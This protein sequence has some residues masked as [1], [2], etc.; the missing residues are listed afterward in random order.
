MEKNSYLYSMNKSEEHTLEI[1]T[2]QLSEERKGRRKAE[3]KLLAMEERHASEMAALQKEIASLREE[4]VHFHNGSAQM[5]EMSSMVKQLVSFMM[6]NEAVSMSDSLKAAVLPE[7]RKEFELQKQELCKGFERQKQELIDMYERKITVL[8]ERLR[9]YEEGDDD[10]SS[11]SGSPSDDLETRVKSAEQQCADLRGTAYGQRTESGKYRH[12]RQQAEDADTMDLNGEDVPEE[13]VVK[14]AKAIREYRDM[15]GVSKPRRE[16][17]LAR[18]AKDI[19]LVPENLPEDACE[20]G[21]DVTYRFGYIKGYIRVQRIIRKKYRDS[22]GNYY[23]I[24]LPEKYRNCM[25]R[26]QATETLI[27]QILTMH[28]QQNMTLGDIEKWLRD[29]GVNFSHSTVMGW[30][31]LAA[32]MLAPLDEPLKEEI[33]RSGNL[34]S[35][36]STLKCRDR[37]LP[38]KGENEADVEDDLHFFKRWMFCHH[39]PELK[40]TQF[41]FHER[42]RRTQEA[43]QTYLK[44]VKERLW[45]HSDG[46]P[47]YKCYD[48]HELI[49]RVACL[50]HMRRPFFKLKDVYPDASRIVDIYDKIFHRDKKIKERYPDPEDRRKQRVIQIAPLLHELKSILDMLAIDLE[51]AKEPELLQAVKYALKEYPCILHCLEDGSLDLSNNVCER[52][53]RRLAKYRNNSF[54]VGSPESAERFARLMSLFANIEAHKLDPIAFL[55]DVFRRIKTCVREELVNLLPHRWQPATVIAGNLNAIF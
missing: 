5:D 39:S 1:L 24:N 29:M 3:K 19:I 37:R 8:M 20:I 10:N 46:A 40:L 45:I 30:I 55:T 50:V 34:H 2:T 26:T 44:D 23:C 12:G 18:M 11:S 31:E 7:L 22:R 52:E 13:T 47:L 25:G 16:Q 41:I 33:T 42:G 9:R 36:E 6:G 21:R 14:I 15:K 32:N 43:I 49:V 35:D 54:F 28:F 4:L 48:V 51:K 38:G 27:A 53:I 17:P